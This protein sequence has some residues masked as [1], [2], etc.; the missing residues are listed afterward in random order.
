MTGRRYSLSHIWNTGVGGVSP[1][2]RVQ[3]LVPVLAQSD[4][5]LVVY[6]CTRTHS[7]ASLHPPP[8]AQQLVPVVA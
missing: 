3:R 4:C 8:A 5:L 2:F 1:V 7:L 6:R